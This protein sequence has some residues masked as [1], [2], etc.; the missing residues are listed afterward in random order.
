MEPHRANQG[1]IGA[2]NHGTETLRTPVKKMLRNELLN[3]GT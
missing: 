3:N 2:E 1:P